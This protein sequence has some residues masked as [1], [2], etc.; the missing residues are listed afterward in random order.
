MNYKNSKH[1][2]NRRIGESEVE[3]LYGVFSKFGYDGNKGRVCVTVKGAEFGEFCSDD[4]SALDAMKVRRKPV[5]EIEFSYRNDDY[6]SRVSLSIKDEFSLL[7]SC[8][9][10]LYI[11]IDSTDEQWFNSTWKR[12]EDVVDAIPLT[13]LSSRFLNKWHGIIAI[14]FAIA[15]S[16]CTIRIVCRSV[17]WLGYVIP[18]NLAVFVMLAWALIGMYYHSVISGFIC[19]NYPVV[20]LDLY[21]KRSEIRCRCSRLFWWF[22]GVIGSLTIATYWPFGKQVS[23][24]NTTASQSTTLS[25]TSRDAIPRAMQKIEGDNGAK[26]DGANTKDR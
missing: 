1:I 2:R 8:S 17:G 5:S 13:P 9:T 16:F 7:F 20:D 22:V 19:R 6:T 11:S 12:M 26:Q 24:K 4:R 25:E 18:D 15:L 14:L 10:G 3:L 21:K 23:E